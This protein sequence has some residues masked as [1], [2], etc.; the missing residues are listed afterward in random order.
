M[1]IFM[2][3]LCDVLSMFFSYLPFFPE[4]G[5]F[6]KKKKKKVIIS[7]KDFFFQFPLCSLE[8]SELFRAVKT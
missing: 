3:S 8:S 2:L 4:F 5:V 7:F 1:Q 6:S